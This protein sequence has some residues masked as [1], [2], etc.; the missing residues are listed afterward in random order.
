[1]LKAAFVQGRMTKDELD[2]R[3]GQTFAARAYA[4]LAAL[5]AGARFM[6]EALSGSA[7]AAARPARPRSRRRAGPG[8]W[9]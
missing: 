3:V 2:A 1:M 6:A 7:T 4:D 8:A 5:T 9:R